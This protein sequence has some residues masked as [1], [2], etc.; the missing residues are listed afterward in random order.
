MVSSE[1]STP[2][3]FHPLEPTEDPTPDS[4]TSRPV[5]RWREIGEVALAAELCVLATSPFVELFPDGALAWRLVVAGLAGAVPGVLLRLSGRRP[6]PIVSVLVFAGVFVVTVTVLCFHDVAVGG[7]IPSADVLTGVW[8]GIIDGPRQILTSAVPAPEVGSLLLVPVAVAYLAVALAAEITWR[9]RSRLG[10]PVVAVAVFGVALAF[11]PA[12]SGG[13]TVVAAVIAGLSLLYMVARKRT[14]STIA[15]QSN[16]DL[17]PASDRPMTAG[18][19]VVG[20]TALVAVSL[21]LAAFIPVA[22]TRLDLRDFVDA[23]VD[24]VGTVNPL[25]LLNPV[26]RGDVVPTGVLDLSTSDAKL[27]VARLPVARL[28]SFDCTSGFV[29]STRAVASAGELPPIPSDPKTSIVTVNL[30]G[31]ESRVLPAPGNVVQISVRDGRPVYVDPT[32]RLVLVDST[33]IDGVEYRVRTAIAADVDGNARFDLG[34]STVGQA[35]LARCEAAAGVDPTA[36]MSEIGLLHGSQQDR[37]Q[38]LARWC[39]A[40]RA[41]PEVPNGDA[42]SLRRLF[43]PDPESVLSSAEGSAAQKTTACAYLGQR[44]GLPVQ[45]AVGYVAVVSQGRA[46][47]TAKDLSAWLEVTDSDGLIHPVPVLGSPD[48]SAGDPPESS[49]DDTAGDEDVAPPPESPEV[50]QPS[51]LEDEESSAPVVAIAVVIGAVV[52]GGGWRLSRRAR[53]RRR[54]RRGSPE[55]RLAGAWM[56]AVDVLG[57][58]GVIADAFGPE[59]IARTADAFPAAAESDRKS[60]V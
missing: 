37:L 52:A 54:R 19:A 26:Q 24:P 1:P 46:A 16:A 35:E 43:G 44:A 40:L 47:A 59:D 12:D 25:L 51:V 45:V 56:E 2:W 41:N 55:Q 34:P 6:T 49:A 39:Q 57:S 58:V 9:T 7:V 15:T 8:D 5:L 29:S 11:E 60:V 20:V 17:V 10:V 33:P 42:L 14:A 18:I 38:A 31:A 53:R 27:Q 30:T 48:P 50:N 4:G 28:G 36:V 22:S 21:G 23:P 3:W 13:H 32:D